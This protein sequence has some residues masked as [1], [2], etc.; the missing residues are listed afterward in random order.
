VIAFP[1]AKKNELLF[2]TVKSSVHLLNIGR[3][4]KNQWLTMRQ[5]F[6]LSFFLSFFHSFFSFLF[7]ILELGT[8]TGTL[9][10]HT[11]PPMQATFSSTGQYCITAAAHEALIWDLNSNTLA[12]YLSLQANVVVKQV[13]DALSDCCVG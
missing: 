4:V 5:S 10:G 3:F 6:F 13:Q 2:G 11:V 1:P 7:L 8:L 12:H 9:D